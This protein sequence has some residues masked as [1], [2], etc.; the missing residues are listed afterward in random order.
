[1]TQTEHEVDTA[2]EAIQLPEELTI[3]QSNEFHHR[4]KE[5]IEKGT[6]IV[7]DGAAVTRIDTAF[8]QLLY[9]VQRTLA[10]A[11]NRLQWA[12]TSEAICR[13]VELLGMSEHL[14]LTEAN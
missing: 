13:S 2:V 1:M 11:G 7:L 12:N 5:L 4:F 3:A 9:Q 10:E 8:I 14:A 6:D